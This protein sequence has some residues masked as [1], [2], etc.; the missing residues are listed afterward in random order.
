MNMRIF[1]TLAAAMLT[2][3]PTTA[4]QPPDLSG[5]LRWR[6]IGPFRGGR[7][8]AVAGIAS[9]PLVYYMGATGGG[10]WKT[11]DAGL[12]W[13]NVSDG[14]FHAGSVG[15]VSVSQSNPNIVYVGTGE[16]CL[17]GNLSSG[18]GVYKSTDAG[19]T[20]T[21]VG[22]TDSSQI[23]RLQIHPTNPDIVYVAA[24]GHPYGPNAER[25]VFRSRDGGKTWQ[26]VLYV[27]DKTGAADIAMDATNPQVLYA[28]TWQVLRTPWDIYS[29]GPGGGIY[30]ST[31]GGDT[32]TKLTAG[33][34]SGNLGKIG[35]AVSPA[36]PQRVWATLEADARGGVYRSDDAGR[37]WQLLNDDFNM[38]SRQYYYGHIF[39][40]P[41][42]AN[43]VYTFCAKYFYKST[44]GGRTYTEIQTPHGD[45]HDLWIDPR[46]PKRM[47]NGSDGGASVTFNGGR[48]WS[49]QDNQPTG[50][51]YAV[52][53]DH[54]TPYRVYGSQQDNTTVSIASR[55][56][57]AGIT[58]A[59]WH[60]VGGGESGYLAPTAS[61]PPVIFGGSYFGLMTRYDERTG[62]SQN[63]TVWPDYNGGRTAADVKYRFQWTY[64]IVVSPHDGN[65]VYAG[66]Q[67]LFRSTN[68]GR[69]WDTISPDL[70]RND[71]AKQKGGRLEEYYST[72]FTIAESP[73]EK[74]VIWT[75]SDDGL[76]QLTR[77][78]GR[79]WQNVTPP[80]IQPYTRINIIEASPHDAAVAFVA[81]NRYQLDDYRPYLY[82]TS[83]YGRSWQPIANG[84][85]ERAFVRTVREDPK[86]RDLLYAGTEAGVY[87]SLDGGSRWQ[88]LQLNLPVVPVTD[89]AV[90]DNDLVASTQGRAFWILDD[91]TPL[92]DL[93][94]AMTSDV[95]LV[96]PRDAVRARRGGFG[97]A[98][99]GAGQNPP[100][101]AVV[102]YWL[103]RDQ[104]VAI[105]IVDAKGAVVKHATSGDRNGP[106]R[107]RGLHRFTWDMRY[108]DAHGIEGGTFLAGGNLR[109]PIAVPG[110]YQVRL[111]AA[112]TTETQALRIVADPRSTA[113][114]A[115]L[116]EQFDLLIMIR[117]RVS[118]VHDAANDIVKMRKA[119]A[120]RKD[121]ASLRQNAALE[122]V[123]KELV[124]LRFVGYDDQMLVFDLKLN[125]RM[126]ALQGYVSQGDYAP[127][128]QQYSVFRSLSSLIDAALAKYA[129]LKAQAPSP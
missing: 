41:V 56:N 93:A 85:P 11:D 77:N 58:Q 87:F 63:I 91:L 12:T 125:N 84:I 20:W 62:D 30:K 2:M 24:I 6:N 45:Y 13:T 43:T 7:V 10:V 50:Q 128:E 61:T 71:A 99:S 106:A 86:R 55:T 78:G 83:D 76:V 29:T 116:Q 54:G 92:H 31:D 49:S 52:I 5:A 72:I 28:T 109:G 96:A 74:G 98:P 66:A 64:P 19:T 35:V 97:R 103:G 23:G 127:T 34:P 124:E 38:T 114:G 42:D 53:A 70:T 113:S 65:T 15:A 121:P 16:G 40:D 68:G 119:L 44:D 8:T 101:G 107:T 122:A 90:K 36:D 37:S 47:V 18:D 21:H 110:T 104:D 46:D 73:K 102:T 89:L 67:L 105:D 22:L 117:D 126:A 59:D 100:A 111:T 115:E 1:L 112:G 26:K 108:P 39:A 57:G 32:W 48:T 129:A 3:Q 118:A 33:L 9:Q 27:N 51:F 123:Q 4:Q 14:S 81:A 75:G 120:S 69:S 25:G 17:R 94:G 88:S 82:K 60:P 79:D 80:A 95:H